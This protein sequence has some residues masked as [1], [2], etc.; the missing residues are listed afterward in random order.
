M[1]SDELPEVPFGELLSQP[2][3]NGLT[4]PRRVRG[5]GVRMVNM[6]ELFGNRRIGDIPMERVPLN[7]RNRDRDLL[8]EQ[9]LLF[10]RQSIV[11][12]GAGKVALFT[13][14]NEPV[15]FESHLIRARIDSAKADPEWLFYFFESPLGRSR[16]QA[17]VHQ[18]AAAGIR[19]S[20]LARVQ[21]PCPDVEEQH[22]RARVLGVL[23]DKIESNRRI[24]ATLEEIAATLFKAR[25]VDFIDHDD[26]VEGDIGPI[27]RGWAVVPIAALA[28]YV[29]GKAFTKY[30]NDRGRMVI[31]I[32]ELRSGP[33]GSTV[34]TDHEAESD[35]MAYPGDILFAWS[36]SLD[37]YRW[38]RDPALI[39]QHIF[40]VIPSEYPPWFAFYALKHVMPH[41]RAIAADKA[42]TMGH[43]KRSHLGEYFLAVPPADE[44]ATF[45][46]AFRPAFDFALA[47]RVETETLAALRDALL[48]K[49]I[50]GQI[51]VPDDAFEG[52]EAG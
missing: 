16:T 32:A 27:P 1:S 50:S 11:A 24:A 38:H 25:F 12:D 4:R 36:G 41:F 40:K 8:A 42:T 2:L 47:A 51:R 15:T 52:V 30:G 39:N 34:Y 14:A 23:D 37:V 28:R 31:R 5:Q 22:R 13:G 48:P 49:L 29:N 17:M 26:L 18:V 19:G 7:E 9:D 33:S 44:L 21:V 6:G 3:R 20:D 35:F 43:I 45:D 46:A 10:A